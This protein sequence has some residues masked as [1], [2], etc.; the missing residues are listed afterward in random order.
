MYKLILLII[1]FTLV[2]AF[3]KAGSLHAPLK[4]FSGWKIERDTSLPEPLKDVVKI[5]RSWE[6]P[7]TLKNVSGI[8]YLEPDRIACIQDEVGSIFIYNL[9]SKSIETEIPFGPPGDY[10]GIA[11]VNDNAYVAC[12]DGRIYEILNYRSD[13]PV[14]KEYGTHLTVKQNVEGLCL[15]HKNN[16]LLVA[17]KGIDEGNR[18]Y[19]GVYAFDLLS[20]AMPVKPVLKIDL[21]DSVFNN[22][23]PKNRQMIFQPSDI[24]IQPVTQ[25]IYI[26]DGTRSQLLVMG[27]SGNIKDLHNL[28]KTIFVQPEGITFTPSG[29]L[30]IASKGVKEEPGMLM[31]VQFK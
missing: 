30:Y 11:L 4:S 20:K 3:L 19:K 26:A 23:Q 25:D 1:I 7:S 17:I 9:E 16:R 10:E 15:D 29:E 13:K 18:N 2:F 8:D 31:L 6:F 22:L 14:V 24:D 28:N 12:A 5:T 21:K 27:E